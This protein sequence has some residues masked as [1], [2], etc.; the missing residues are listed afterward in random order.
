[1]PNWFLLIPIGIIGYLVGGWASLVYACILAFIAFSMGIT[2]AKQRSLALVRE[3]IRMPIWNDEGYGWIYFFSTSPYTHV[4]IGKTNNLQRRLNEHQ[5]ALQEPI[6][7][8][9]AIRVRDMDSVESCLHTYYR[10]LKSPSGGDEWYRVTPQMLE[11]IMLARDQ[12]ISYGKLINGELK[13]V[14]DNTDIL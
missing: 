8:L 4:K 1:M 2:T 9:G 3:Y 12:D 11:W 13:K 6:T 14:V 7:L 10:D 5:T